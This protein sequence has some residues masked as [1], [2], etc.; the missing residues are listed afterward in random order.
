MITSH[1][2]FFQFISIHV[3]ILS[4]THHSWRV[5]FTPLTPHTFITAPNFSSH[6][7]LPLSRRCTL[8]Q[9]S[10]VTLSWA[11]RRKNDDWAAFFGTHANSRSSFL[12]EGSPHQMNRGHHSVFADCFENKTFFGCDL[13]RYFVFTKC[14]DVMKPCAKAHFKQSLIRLLRKKI[15]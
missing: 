10:R 5:S 11:P 12:V 3:L 1:E 4:T 13:K 6:A 8:D 2:H 7:L 15:V 14:S 9:F